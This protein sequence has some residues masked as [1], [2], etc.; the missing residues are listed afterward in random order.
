MSGYTDVEKMKK[1]VDLWIQKMIASEEVSKRCTGIDVTM[2]FEIYD[3]DL[4]FYMQFKDGT[5]GGGLGEDD[6]PSMVFLEMSS[7]TLDGMMLGEIDG[8]SAAM[9]GQMTIS[10]DMGAAMGLQAV[11]DVMN[12]LYEEAKKEELG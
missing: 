2:G 3:P 8:A 5:V 12:I 10:G 11:G 6:P 7:E 1:V 4:S 9:S